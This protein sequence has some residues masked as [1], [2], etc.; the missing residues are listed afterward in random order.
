[1]SWQP[2]LVRG[3]LAA[4][5]GRAAHWSYVSSV[6][7]YASD[8]IP[9]ADETAPLLPPPIRTGGVEQYGG[10]KVACEQSSGRGV[11]RRP[12]IGGRARSVGLGDAGDPCIRVAPAARDTA[13]AD[14]TSRLPPVGGAHRL[15]SSSADA[16]A[17]L[18]EQ[19]VSEWMGEESLPVWVA[20]P[21]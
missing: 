7:V 6:S 5:G 1:M 3:A 8:A 16:R 14:A 19:G 11:D 18:L 20:E 9:G 15:R 12:L 4:L 21:G 13:R 17:W 2:G 10:A